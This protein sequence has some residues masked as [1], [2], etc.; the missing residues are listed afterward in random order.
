MN[1]ISEVTAARLKTMASA[2]LG[3]DIQATP[4]SPP[5]ISHNLN[6]QRLGRKGRDTRKRILDAVHEMLAE[7]SEEQITL[8]AVAR[9]ASLGMTT[10]YAY[11]N[12]LTELLLAVLEPIMETA[13]ESHVGLLRRRWDDAELDRCSLEFVTAYYAFWV[14]HSRLLHLRNTMSD[15]G[16]ER[17]RLHRVQSAQPMMS[18]FV[19]QMDGDLSKPRTPVFSM[20]TVLMTGLERIVTVITGDAIP[21]PSDQPVNPRGLLLQAEARLFEL[22]VRDHRRLADRQA[23]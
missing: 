15:A 7:A 18:L 17:M 19:L 12:D 2:H 20:A 14:K 9:R 16:D 13:E 11:F 10:L 3:D 21:F 22:G 4:V 5:Q 8:T 6:G 1:G 23:G